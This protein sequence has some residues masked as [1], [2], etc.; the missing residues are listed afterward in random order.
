M[1]VIVCGLRLKA[2]EIAGDNI[3]AFFNPKSEGYQRIQALSE[4]K[5]SDCLCGPEFLLYLPTHQQFVT[6]YMASKTMKKEAPNLRALLGKGAT[7]KATLLKK[8]KYVWHGPVITPCSMALTLPDPEKLKV[9]Q[10]KFTSESDSE[11]VA[12]PGTAAPARER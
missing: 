5:D 4:V 10:V 12:A 11:V 1:Q 7:L 6:F 2:L 3:S 8:Q 9:E